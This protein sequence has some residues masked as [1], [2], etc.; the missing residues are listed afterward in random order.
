[1]RTV[2]VIG[3]SVAA[4][5]LGVSVACGTVAA[6]S[7][8]VS[9]TCGAVAAGPLGVSVACGAVAAGPLGVS[10]ACGSVAAEPLGVSVACGA[11]AAGPLGV[12]VACGSVAAGPLG[13]SVACGAVF[14]WISEERKD[15]CLA[16]G[17]FAFPKHRAPKAQPKHRNTACASTTESLPLLPLRCLAPGGDGQAMKV[18]VVGILEAITDL[19]RRI[20]A[21][22]GVRLH[23]LG[24]D[25]SGRN[26]TTF[27]N[28]HA[29]Q[30][31]HTIADPDI[32]AHRDLDITALP[33]VVFVADLP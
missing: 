1:M 27:P 8:G 22:D 33:V 28:R 20:A 2:G 3:V 29:A 5:P 11:V 6:R 24:H 30:N 32:I 15:R 26:H 17:P 7:L 21:N 19:T 9:V 12:S 18:Q 14:Q 16:T 31:D 4:E 23:V 25:S 13:V 10:V